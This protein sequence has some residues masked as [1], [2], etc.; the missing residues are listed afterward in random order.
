MLRFKI[1][2]E[3]LFSGLNYVEYYNTSFNYKFKKILKRLNKFLDDFI[4]KMTE[5]Y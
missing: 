2:K 1:K 4:D 5:N 3:R